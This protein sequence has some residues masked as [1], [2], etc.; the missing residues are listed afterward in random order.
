MKNYVI[1]VDFGTR[2]VRSIIIDAENGQFMATSEFTYPRWE[3]TE[4]CDS[5]KNQY[6][7]HPKDYIEGI[8]TTVI[9]CLNK[10]PSI[11]R[12]NIRS[13][14]IDTTGSTPVAVNK[15]GV[16]LSLLPEFEENPNAMFFLWKDHTAIKEAEEINAHAA[17]FEIDYLKYCG[18]IYSSEW[19]WAKLLFALRN[20]EKIR[21][22]CYS[23]V[24]HCDWMPFLL[25]GGKDV[26]KI[27]R[28]ACAAGH[29]ALWAKEFDGLPPDK[30]FSEL[31]PLLKGFRERL[32]TMT[33]TADVPVGTLSEEWADRLQLSK[34]VLVGTGAL[35]AHMGAVGACI[36][37]YFLSKVMGTSTCD[38]LVVPSEE[39]KTDV[40]EGI[41]GQ[42]LGSIIPGM[43]GM[44][45]GQSAFGDAYAWFRDIIS[46]PIENMDMGIN[47]QNAQNN[48]LEKLSREAEKIEINEYSEISVDWFNGR[49]TPDANQEVHAALCGLNLS[50]NAPSLFRSIAE[51]TCFGAKKI[52][53]RFAAEGIELKGLI[54]TGGVAKKSPFIMQMMA[55]VIGMPIKIN[56]SEETTALGAAMFAATVAGIYPD[57]QQAMK[58]M[59]QDFDKVYKP[60]KEKQELYALRYEKY[61]RICDFI[62]N[63]L[64]PTN[65][66]N[67]IKI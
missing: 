3:R 62:E 52:V 50:S 13:I 7:Q 53:E 29:K 27:K 9:G 8:E 5:A 24:E 17:K 45:A 30:F 34:D 49:R 66:R 6:R 55:D 1:G 37:P 54:G 33:F 28:S 38:M 44:E 12:G 23:W 47:V 56:N 2:S 10:V 20:D 67:E 42:A 51:G 41:C 26:S 32:Y 14:S 35:D 21:K 15:N 22:A 57:V 58:V 11:V 4:F 46:W 43:I 36:E 64:N 40:V 25:T 59:G 48:I 39:N 31:D 19:F 18:G 60:K 61:K 63:E 65:L 16:P